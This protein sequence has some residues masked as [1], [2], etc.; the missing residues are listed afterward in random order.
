MAKANIAAWFE[1]GPGATGQSVHLVLDEQ[2]RWAW[3]KTGWFSTDLGENKY[4]AFGPIQEA[5]V[6]LRK[7]GLLMLT[8]Y[9]IAIT[10][11]DY[12]GNGYENE[13]VTLVFHVNGDAR[14][15][16][17][18][19]DV[20]NAIKRGETLQ[21]ELLGNLRR[22]LKTRARVN[23]KDLSAELYATAQAKF[24][25]AVPAGQ[26]ASSEAFKDW[27]VTNTEHLI[28]RGELTGIID[29]VTREYL[30]RDMSPKQHSVVN[31]DVSLDFKDLMASLAQGGLQVSSVR[32]PQC[33]APC[34]LPAK[35][36]V[37]VCPHCSSTLK[38][39]DVVQIL[40]KILSAT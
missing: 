20:F 23:L 7:S 27:V 33:A 17:E 40:R 34:P 32:C 6:E 12:T 1:S 22:R 2:R 3:V 39:A 5:K 19:V 25:E 37:V 15:A 29:P 26:L 13:R 10:V 36:D 38:V 28:D 14:Q 11:E 9:R 30:D 16:K 21:V 35:G 24:K 8:E 4:E 18:F 31:L